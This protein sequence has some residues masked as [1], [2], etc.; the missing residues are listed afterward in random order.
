MVDQNENRNG[1]E[2]ANQRRMAELR[3]DLVTA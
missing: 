1:D 3:F 2:M